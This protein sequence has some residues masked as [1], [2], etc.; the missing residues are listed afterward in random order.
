MPNESMDED[1]VRSD[2]K[3]PGRRIW[4]QASAGAYAKQLLVFLDAEL[5]V[6]RVSAGELVKQLQECG[7]IPPA[8]AV[9]VSNDGAA[10]RH[11]DFVCD[12]AY[13]DFLSRD[14]VPHVLAKHSVHSEATVLIGLSL[15]GLA[16]AHATLTTDRFG[17]AVCQSP[18]FWWEGERLAS[19]LTPVD[20]R[21]PKFWVSVG[22]LE[23]DRHVS[24]PPSGLFQATSQRDSCE[25]VSAALGAAGYEV[26]YR[27]F[28]GGHDTACWRDDLAL[29]L[30]WATSA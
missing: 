18:S 22:D 10:A 16:A 8:V 28:Q 30:P 15:S 2:L 1:F 27:L 5:Y 3:P 23:T 20:G 25:R 13:A 11:A 12:A 21:A 9:F 19:L 26:A 7:Q 4:T 14:L 17:V 29:A 6:E 24:H